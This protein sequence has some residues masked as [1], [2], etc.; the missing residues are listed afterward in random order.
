MITF[1]NYSSRSNNSNKLNTFLNGYLNSS[2]LEPNK[3]KPKKSKQKF[4]LY[5]KVFTL[6]SVLVLLSF[7]GFTYQATIL[8]E[9]YFNYPTVVDVDIRPEYKIRLPAIT[10]C[11][12]IQ[13]APSTFKELF[14]NYPGV[15]DHLNSIHN[16]SALK[17]IFKQ[18][19]EYKFLRRFF[20][21]SYTA[22]VPLN[23]SQLLSISVPQ[24]AFIN[25]CV[26]IF[27]NSNNT[28]QQIPCS[29]ISD[30]HISFTEKHKCF[31]TLV[32]IIELIQMN[33]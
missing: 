17:S 22:K 13:I 29:K 30:T 21:L 4:N 9:R 15:K 16:N 7:V 11:T 27:F 14:I 31:L 12:P 32:N 6:K 25:K 8:S 26:V 28:S 33:Y 24:D 20:T 2:N 5:K 3:N 23:L 10:V 1:G 18:A 19:Q